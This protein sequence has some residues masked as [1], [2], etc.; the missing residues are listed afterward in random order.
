MA[1]AQ[2]DHEPQTVDCDCEVLKAWQKSETVMRRLTQG[3]LV[4]LPSDAKKIKREH[5]GENVDLLAPI[6][7]NLG[8]LNLNISLLP[9]T[10]LTGPMCFK[11][12]PRNPEPRLT[13]LRAHPGRVLPQAVHG[14]PTN[15]SPN[16]H[17]LLRLVKF[18]ILAPCRIPI[19]FCN[20]PEVMKSRCKH[21]WPVVW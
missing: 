20:L 17:E 3:M 8:S 9:P 5:L 21:G 19:V 7:E 15:A 1:K 14:Q 13:P 18:L 10:L 6:L 4:H 11:P 2:E 16:A 12:Q